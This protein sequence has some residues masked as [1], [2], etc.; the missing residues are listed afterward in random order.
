MSSFTTS[1]TISTSSFCPFLSKTSQLSIPK[2]RN[3]NYVNPHLISCKATANDHDQNPTT[4]RDILI[5]LGG[6]YVAITL[7]DPLAFAKPVSAPDLTKCGKADLPSSAKPTNCCPP[8]STK[9]LDF[10][11]PSSNS[12]LRIR[13][14]AHVV[15]DAYL[16]KYS[17]AIELMK[18]LPDDDPRSFMQQANVHCAYCDGAYHQ[19]GLPDL[20]LQVHNSWLFFPFHR[21]FLYFHEKILG[22]LIDD[23]TFALPFWNWDSPA[24]MQLPAIYVDPKSPL[25]D[26][27]RNKNHQPPTL[28]DLDYNG[29]ENPTSKQ[30]LLSS[31]LTIMY[32]QMVS[33]GKTARLFHGSAYR[34]GDEADPGAGS[35]ENIPHGP[36]HVWCGDNTQPNLE[37]MGN[38][39]SAARDPIF[40]AHHS[41]VDRMWTIWKTLGGNKR[42]EFTDPDWLDAEFIFYDE[43]ANPVRVKVR[44]CIDTK[45]LGYIY[46]DVDIPWLKSRPKSRRLIKKVANKV[47]HHDGQAAHAAETLNLPPITAFPLVLDKVIS[48]VAKR[49]K[50]SRSKKEKEEEEEVLLIDA[51]EFERNALVKF[52]VYVNDEHDSTSARPDNSEFAGSFVNIPHKH[53]HGKKMKTCLR[54]GLTDLLED[55]GAEDD[56]TVVVTLVPRYGKG[57]VKIG[58]I[59]ID[60]IQD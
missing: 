37:D 11:L 15:D 45:K 27:F 18:A 33:N 12:P 52:D 10:K 9:I 39:Y 6:L 22:K 41:N 38:F 24:G 17:K 2:N 21:Y 53:K 30:E 8:P 42:T 51:I 23:P 3:C 58:G 36:V 57:L 29:S 50:K 47:F 13:P 16:A 26:Q 7:G 34:A 48:T 14:A 1:I 55:M 40:F 60:Y 44:D 4:R 32:R 31:N 56:D 28:V 59:M 43:N 25:Y 54:L 46:Q 19:V 5:V 20:D 49:P 35:I